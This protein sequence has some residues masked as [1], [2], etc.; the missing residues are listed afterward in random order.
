MAL[1]CE[2]VKRKVY[3]HG[4][5]KECYVATIRRSGTVDFND[6]VDRIENACTVTHADILAVLNAT[7]KVVMDYISEGK[8]V[9]LSDLCS[10]TPTVNAKA[11]D[12]EEDVSA[13][14]ITRVGC[15]CKPSAK[16]KQKLAETPV[17][18][19]PHKFFNPYFAGA[20]IKKKKAAASRKVKFN[21]KSDNEL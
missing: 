4:K 16:I 11:C 7:Q 17:Y 18:I 15:I 1:Y 20:E 10:F 2:R 3:S 12:N 9:K 14:T 13:K 21:V 5:T 19:K 6:V 8:S